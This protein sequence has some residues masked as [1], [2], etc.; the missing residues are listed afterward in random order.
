M[1]VFYGAEKCPHHL[2]LNVSGESLTTVYASITALPFLS[3]YCCFSYLTDTLKQMISDFFM[4]L[5]FPW[6]F[7]HL[8][9]SPKVYVWRDFYHWRISLKWKTPHKKK[10]TNTSPSGF[11]ISCCPLDNSNAILFICHLLQFTYSGSAT[12]ISHYFLSK[13]T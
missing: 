8:S 4:F 7:L 5:Q 12:S 11:V 3:K 9:A 13:Y 2:L 1:G 6:Q 10:Q